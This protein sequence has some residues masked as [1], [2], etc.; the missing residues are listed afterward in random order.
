MFCS[1]EPLVSRH[2][3][4][5]HAETHQFARKLR[6]TLKI[7]RCLSDL[8]FD[9]LPLDVPKLPKT[10]AEAFVGG[11]CRRIILQPTYCW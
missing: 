10:L 5:I 8:N 2:I 6:E 4:D 9:V 7:A 3:E 11:K 1:P